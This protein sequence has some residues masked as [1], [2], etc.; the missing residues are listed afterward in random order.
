M[1]GA[2]VKMLWYRLNKVRVLLSCFGVQC[3]D[4]KVDGDNLYIS[5]SV[6]IDGEQI[7]FKFPLN[8]LGWRFLR[9]LERLDSCCFGGSVNP[10]DVRVLFVTL[11]T[12]DVIYRYRSRLRKVTGLVKDRKLRNWIIWRRITAPI[13][14]AK[15][16]DRS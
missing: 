3:Y 13:R 11:S 2:N 16:G 7:R 10:E 14:I 5:C 15:K 9:E 4:M 8:R 12:P 6:K 1:K